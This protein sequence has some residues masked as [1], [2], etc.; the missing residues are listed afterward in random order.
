MDIDDI[1]KAYE[2]NPGALDY[3]AVSEQKQTPYRREYTFDGDGVDHYT[4][5]AG[6]TCF[7]EYTFDPGFTILFITYFFCEGETP[8]T[9]AKM[10]H[11]LLIQLKQV[12]PRLT[13]I[14]LTADA[15]VAYNSV[16]QT[17]STGDIDIDQP[18][19]NKY[20]TDIGFVKRSDSN[21]FD[22]LVDTIIGTIRSTIAGGK[23][24]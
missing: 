21:I 2:D 16:N 20:Y 1:D 13:S 12:Y 8:R 10:L 5:W 23:R 14:I 7:I 4:I 18:K 3:L 24:K 15:T 9:G 22:G 17:K 19:L 6:N 11:D